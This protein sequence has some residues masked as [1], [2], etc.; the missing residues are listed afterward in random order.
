MAKVNPTIQNF[1]RGELSPRMRGRYDLDF[2][3]AGTE[4]QKNF[5]SDVEGSATF[6]QGTEFLNELPQKAWLREFIFDNNQS[7]A[8]AFSSDEIRIYS[9]TG[10][11]TLTSTITSPYAEEDI[12]FLQLAQF[13][14]TVYIAH[15]NYQARTLV[16]SAINTWN[17]GT[18][19][20]AGQSEISGADGS[21]N[22]PQAVCIY[23][24]RLIYA[25]TNNNPQSIYMSK[26][27][28]YNDFTVGDQA[29]DGIKYVI[30]SERLNKVL[31]LTPTDTL[32]VV[33]TSGGNFNI[34]SGSTTE[35]ITPSSVKVT[36]SGTRPSSGYQ[37]IQ[38]EN[39]VIYSQAGGEKVYSYQYV[40]ESDGFQSVD[41]TTLSAQITNSGVQGM[42]FAS[43]SPDRVSFV[44]G[45]GKVA[46]LV[47]KPE[48]QVFAW[49]LQET[50]GKVISLCALPQE[51]G[52]DRFMYCIE[53]TIQGQ[54]KYYIEVSAEEYSLPEREDYFTGDKSADDEQYRLDMYEAQKNY[55]FVDSCL[56]FNG[57]TRGVDAG[58]N[59][60]I[61]VAADGT[62]VDIV[63]SASLFQATDVGG[64]VRA[65]TG[66]GWATITTF[67]SATEVTARLDTPFD[68]ATYNAGDYYITADTISGLNH[69]EGEE[70]ALIVDGSEN[71]KRIV[72]GGEVT[73]SDD[74]KRQGSVVHVGLPYS[75]VLKTMP[76]QGQQG[77]ASKRKI[78]LQ[79]QI[80]FLN[81]IA[82]KYGT[83]IYKT[84]ALKFQ[85]TGNRFNRPPEPYS[86]YKK[87]VAPNTT[88]RQQN[89]VVLQESPLPCIIQLMQYDLYESTI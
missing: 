81:T 85:S 75:G 66:E 25:G 46:V 2:Y 70:V 18:H 7:Y 5:V 36:S 45:D 20:I 83:D 41:R 58:A 55:K 30:G 13:K 54:T 44:R 87:C 53:R 79:T 1:T 60:T 43:G 72:S 16:R 56:T 35:P 67:T 80:L 76:I 22:C 26:S 14:D 65:R 77:S 3:Y 32:C 34:S 11:I 63:S 8:I 59:L 89:V 10:Q 86:G 23:E 84:N 73:L 40:F 12:P 51:E 29:D 68:E 28:I 31:T 39:N 4:E 19:G 88:Q 38:V 37:P 62:S 9:T 49:S 17:L 61:T 42:A 27:F 48:Q 78:V 47:W 6:R 64:Q 52:E 50:K 71:E 15:R 69:L 82:C 57:L 21:G 33:G 74:G 24:R